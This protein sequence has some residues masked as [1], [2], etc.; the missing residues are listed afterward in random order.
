MKAA[1]HQGSMASLNVYS[2]NAQDGLLGWATFPMWEE[3][4]QDGVV[5]L[6]STVP[7]GSAA[8]YNEGD[9]LTHEV[10]RIF[11]R[12]KTNS[13]HNDPLIQ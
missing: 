13:V 4:N 6:Y 7:G 8:P 10:S 5:I 12:Y 11:V 9:T 1:L 3:G 2:V